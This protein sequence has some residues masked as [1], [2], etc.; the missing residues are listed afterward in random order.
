MDLV[1]KAR[2]I[3]EETDKKLRGLLEE[4]LDD[5]GLTTSHKYYSLR[6]L[7]AFK[8]GIS[9]NTNYQG[10]REALEALIRER[11][12]AQRELREAHAKKEAECAELRKE[13]EEA[14]RKLCTLDKGP[15][16]SEF[17]TAE[18][19]EKRRMEL[20]FA[21][22]LAGKVSLAPPAVFDHAQEFVAEAAKRGLL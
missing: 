5:G 1:E 15:D 16:N 20:S 12:E 6:N 17:E 8:L 11:N 18:E 10:I 3:L 22:A 7:L 14:E 9:E 19:S 21:A 13:L 4:A 2:T